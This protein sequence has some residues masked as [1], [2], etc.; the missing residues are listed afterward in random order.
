MALAREC[1]G[2]P[3]DHNGCCLTR[4]AVKERA[5]SLSRKR[6]N[7]RKLIDTYKLE[8]G[9]A[10]CG[11]REDAVA[12]DLDHA[13]PATKVASVSDL[14]SYASWEGVLAELLKC[15]VLCSNCH[16]IKTHRETPK[17]A[18]TASDDGLTVRF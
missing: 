13:D 17:A 18:T 15:R 2:R 9:C 3:E 10:R 7:R 12:L 14:L 11:Y 6:A 1:C 4:Q 8:R 16:R 5:D